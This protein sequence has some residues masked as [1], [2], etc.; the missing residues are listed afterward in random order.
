M[1]KLH[2]EYSS[3]QYKT[4]K[5]KTKFAVWL[6]MMSKIIVATV[7]VDIDMPSALLWHLQ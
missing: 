5:E 7:R 3:L 1:S 4:D 6:W 2:D